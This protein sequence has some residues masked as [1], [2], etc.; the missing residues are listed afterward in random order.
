MTFY[1][2]VAPPRTQDQLE[3]IAWQARAALGLRPYERVPVLRLVELAIRKVLPEFD[4]EVVDAGKL[5]KAE[6]VTSDSKALIKFDERTYYGLERDDPRS[7]MTAV[8]EVGHL[9]LHTNQTAFAFQRGYDRSVDPEWQ[10]D[11][12]AA[13][14][15]MP[16]CAFRQ[17][18]S[19]RAARKAFGVSKA[20]AW[21]RARQLRMWNLLDGQR[22]QMSKKKGGRY[23]PHPLEKPGSDR[24]P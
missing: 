24:G 4:Y 10:A 12:F 16:E 7:R 6:A 13:A 11:V 15:L 2:R 3:E 19:I 23:D 14:F 20:A 8:H 9:L 1:A 21:C 5:G 18:P 22:P 17:M